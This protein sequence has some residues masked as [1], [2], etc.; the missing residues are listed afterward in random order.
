M[1][2]FEMKSHLFLVNIFS[3]PA[4]Q[5]FSFKYIFNNL[6]S[7][8]FMFLSFTETHQ[9][10]NSELK[11]VFSY[12]F[13]ERAVESITN[14][15]SMGLISRLKPRVGKSLKEG[16]WVSCANLRFS[17]GG[18]GGGDPYVITQGRPRCCSPFRTH[19]KYEKRPPFPFSCF[20]LINF[21]P[22]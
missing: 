4:A 13:L 7:S 6:I 22:S 18:G 19:T 3:Y 16:K 20:V 17:K 9:G 11:I 5:Y 21:H 2:L 15:I 12:L 14:C 1:I 10:R 8:I